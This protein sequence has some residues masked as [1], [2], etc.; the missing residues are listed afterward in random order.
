M[1][2]RKVKQEWRTKRGY[3]GKPV[4]KVVYTAEIAGNYGPQRFELYGGLLTENLVQATARDVFAY[5]ILKLT[6]AGHRVIF[7]SHDEVI[8]EA[9]LETDPK[10]VEKI[11]SCPPPW[12]PGCPLAAEA[13]EATHYKK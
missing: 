4:Q 7:H 8:V 2:Y 1:R 13:K 3:D 12:L 9:A 11:M 5:H 10:E 6:E